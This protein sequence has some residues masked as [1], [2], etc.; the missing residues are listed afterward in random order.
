M[1]ENNVK[2]YLQDHGFENIQLKAVLFDM[3]GVLFDSMPTHAKA[4]AATSDHYHLGLSE[5]EAYENEGRTAK[6]TLNILFQRKEGRDATEEEV[7][8]IYD[9]KIQEYNRYNVDTIPMIGASELMAKIKKD[10]FQIILVTGSGQDTLMARLERFYPDIFTK[11][12]MITAKNV[13][14]GKPNPEPYLQ[15][16]KCANVK[17]WEAIVVENAPLG[18]QAG[19]NANIFTIAVNTGP[20]NDSK[21]LNEGANVL[22]HSMQE[23]CNNWDEI[24]KDIQ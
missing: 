19:V 1:I 21:L 14:M 4:W 6:S 20:I 23:L 5:S 10:G 16:L 13:K 15:G 18:V 8:E 9:Y 12:V 17:P 24:K 3:D 2:S 22:Y 7:K 11:D